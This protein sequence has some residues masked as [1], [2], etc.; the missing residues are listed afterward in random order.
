M[1]VFNLTSL[2]ISQEVPRVL[3]KPINLTKEYVFFEKLLNGKDDT[4]S[5]GIWAYHINTHQMHR[6]DQGQH[7]AYQELYDFD[8]PQIFWNGT[9]KIDPDAMYF[10]TITELDGEEYIEFY[11]ID[12]LS[13]V[14][15]NV[16]GFRF[17]KE[18]LYYKS[19]DLLAPGYI[20]LRL[21][22]NVEYM[23]LEF[24]DEVYLIDVKEKSYYP[25]YDEIFKISAGSLI[26]S[27]SG[28]N[29]RVFVEEYYLEEEEQYD[30]LTSDEV[31]LVFELPEGIDLD[32]LYKNSIRTILLSD[33]VLQVKEGR[34]KIELEIIDEMFKDGSLRLI[35]ETDR[36]I[37]YKKQYYD[38]VLKERGDFLS[39]RKIGSY[40]LYRLDKATLHKE[41]V[42]D[43]HG[44]I[45]IKTS[46]QRAY[47][48]NESRFHATIEDAQTQEIVFDY[49]KRFVGRAYESVAE[50]VNDEYFIVNL[51][52]D[53]PKV[54]SYMIVDVK[55]DEMIVAGH[56]V[57]ILQDYIF[58][59]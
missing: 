17:P 59:I 10:A 3:F 1:Q 7:V 30:I 57:L 4:W 52:S 33:F 37:F 42:R 16:L 32:I 25:I 22:Y 6:M 45:R 29:A 23:D 28:E 8:T 2:N 35:G 44:D 51:R 55:T 38:F 40:E 46:T 58:V 47:I 15:R 20:L 49:K 48:I 19:M 9:S 24:F 41:L 53:D 21:C 11:E 14:Q 39:L 12:L 36:D 56:D 31:E 34:E 54:A 18:E 27:G 26:V 43:I 5:E 50:L 13:G